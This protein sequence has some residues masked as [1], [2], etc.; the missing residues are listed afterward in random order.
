MVRNLALIVILTS[1]ASARCLAQEAPATAPAPIIVVPPLSGPL[2]KPIE[3]FNGKDLTGWTWVQRAPK[4]GSATTQPSPIDAIWSVHDGLLHDKGRPIGYIRTTTEYANFVLTVEQLHVNKGN[5]GVLFA[6]TGPDKV[7]PHCIEAQS[8]N[9]EEGDFRNVADFKM[10]M[11]ASRLEPKRLRRIGPDPEKPVGQWE[12]FVITVDHG[13]LTLTINGSLQNIA[14]N[15]QDL[16]G[17][18]GLQ[19]EGGVIEY[20]KIEL[21]PILP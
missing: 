2:G 10:T 3:L 11:D 12:T 9:G 16:T 5:G 15:T 6:M 7:W 8:L 4:A 20:R 18:I 21:T 1:L 14:T 13:N 19:A 17:R